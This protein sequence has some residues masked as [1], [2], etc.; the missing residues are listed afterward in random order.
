MLSINVQLACQQQYKI[1]LP[2][3]VYRVHST[4]QL[5]RSIVTLCQ[6]HVTCGIEL[7]LYFTSDAWYWPIRGRAGW[8]LFCPQIKT[9]KII[10]L[11]ED[12]MFKLIQLKTVLL[13]R[14][15]SSLSN[16]ATSKS[17]ANHSQMIVFNRRLAVWSHSDDLLSRLETLPCKEWCMQN[18][19]VHVAPSAYVVSICRS[20]CPDAWHCHLLPYL[21][22]LLMCDE[23]YFCI[24]TMPASPRSHRRVPFSQQVL[25]DF[26]WDAINTWRLDPFSCI[27]AFLLSSQMKGWSRSYFTSTF[28]FLVSDDSC[29]EC[30]L[31]KRPSKCPDQ[32]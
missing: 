12:K 29:I 23:P 1:L 20:A 17:A 19:C 32:C 13:L 7:I 8:K 27:V 21:E 6:K 4:W 2:C 28:G 14:A 30:W 24:A 18:C 15:F 3:L 22:L 16:I 9:S 26:C 11:K 31:L 5:I 25:L 10:D